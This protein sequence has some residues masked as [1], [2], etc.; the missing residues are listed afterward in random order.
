MITLDLSRSASLTP[1]TLRSFVG[2]RYALKQKLDSYLMI[3]FNMM[4]S[5]DHTHSPLSENPIN[6]IFSGENFAYGNGTIGH[7]REDSRRS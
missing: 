2:I 6:T 4:G 7:G 1:K 5:D 3:E